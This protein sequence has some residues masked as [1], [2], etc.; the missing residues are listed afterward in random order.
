MEAI[1]KEMNALKRLNCFKFHPPGTKF[2]K[3][4]GWQYAPLHM[5]FDIK[6]QDMRYK[7][8]LVAGGNVVD[9]S[10]YVKTSTT[11]HDLSVR[12]LMLITSKNNLGLMVGDINNTFSTAPNIEKVWTT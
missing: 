8:R 11:V 9:A 2:S 1:T 6:K 3:N 5:R 4:Q 12:L 10:N 7:A